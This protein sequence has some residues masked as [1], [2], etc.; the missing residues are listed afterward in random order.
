MENGLVISDVFNSLCFL[1]CFIF[2]AYVYEN[3]NFF[4]LYRN[5]EVS[6]YK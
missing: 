6:T 1:I 4:I 5:V 2:C 3:L